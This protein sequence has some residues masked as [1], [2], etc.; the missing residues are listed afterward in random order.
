MSSIEI[1]LALTE[2]QVNRDLDSFGIQEEFAGK[3][4][5]EFQE[6]IAS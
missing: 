4:I 5:F 2:R 6:P 1:T 3:Q